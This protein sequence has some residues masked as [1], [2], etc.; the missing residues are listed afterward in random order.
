MGQ[1]SGQTWGGLGGLEGLMRYIVPHRNVGSGWA[2]VIHWF[3]G[4]S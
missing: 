2:R 1:Y 3:R 4:E